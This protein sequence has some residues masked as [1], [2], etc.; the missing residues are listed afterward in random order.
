MEY[1]IVVAP[2]LPEVLKPTVSVETYQ[3]FAPEVPDKVAATVNG[4]GGG[5]TT[6]CAT[7]GLDDAEYFESPA[8]RAR[9]DSV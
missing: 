4:L 6:L 3:P 7:T 8:K 1:T 9:M 2:A 5:T